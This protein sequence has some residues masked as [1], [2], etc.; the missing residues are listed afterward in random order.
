M[1]RAGIIRFA[2]YIRAF[3]L[4][5]PAYLPPSG[6]DTG[7]LF[8]F[9]R[10]WNRPLYLWACL[11][12]VYKSVKTKVKIVLIDNA[13]TDPL[14]KQ[15]IKGFERRGM[16]Y[17]VHHMDTNHGDNQ[18]QLFNQYQAQMGKYFLLMDA[19]IIIQP[20][21]DCW[22]LT[23]VDI[24]ERR[25]DLSLLGSCLDKSDFVSYDCAR[26]LEPN[27]SKAHL[28]NLIKMNSPERDDIV[29]NAEVIFPFKPAG[30]LLLAKTSAIRDV[31]L[32]IGNH[33]L[34][35][36]LKDKGYDYGITTRVV[37]RHLSLLNIYD[38]PDYDFEQLN[39]YLTKL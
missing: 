38:Y 15:V 14:V 34:C 7:D 19:D 4:K 12:S 39:K 17:A 29:K 33:V 30:R 2:K 25:P 32:P 22:V 13:S 16:F 26:D 3:F 31:G 9:I 28:N 24:M 1:R 35:K 6:H 23:M 18:Q 10:S 20:S 21:P 37:H 5:E 8:I 36:A 27:A 11:D